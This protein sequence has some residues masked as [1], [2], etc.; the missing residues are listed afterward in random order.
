MNFAHL[1][2]WHAQIHPNKSTPKELSMLIFKMVAIG[3]P[4]SGLMT[5]L[6]S[7]PNFEETSESIADVCK[8]FRFCKQTATILELYLQFW[9][10][11]IYRHQHEILHQPI[12]LHQNQTA[13]CT[14]TSALSNSWAFVVQVIK[15]AVYFSNRTA[16]D[17][18]RVKTLQNK[19]ITATENVRFTLYGRL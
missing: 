15:C 10:W 18:T 16:L 4:V 6:I 14:V 5:A 1:L 19:M 9:F 17:A 7:K 2:C 13:H 11:L 3:S 12:K 8:Y